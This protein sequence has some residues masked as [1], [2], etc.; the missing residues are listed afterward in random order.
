MKPEAW[1]DA[2]KNFTPHPEADAI[3][4]FAQENGIRVY[5]HTLVVAQP[6]AGLVLPGRRRPAAHRRAR[7][8]SRSSRTGCA[9][10]ILSVA[11]YLSDTYGEFGS[12]T[13]PL[14]AFDVVNEVVSDSGEFA[15]G[16]RRS[17]WYRI[18]G[19]EFIDLAFQYADEAFNDEFAAAGRRPSDHAVHQ[20]LQH[21]AGRQAGSP[22]RAGRAPARARCAGRR[23]GAPVPREPRDAGVRARR[24][25]R[26]VRGPAGRAGGHR[27]RRHHRHAGDRR[28][29]SSSRATTTATRSGSS[30]STP[31]T[32]S[33]S[34][35]GASPTA[36]AGAATP[37]RRSCSTTRCRRSP[38][39]TASSTGSCRRRLRT[40]NVFAERR[41]ARCRR[42]LRRPV[43]AAAA[44]R[45]STTRR[46]FQLRWAPDHL[47]AY[48]TVDDATRAGH[49]RDRDRA[50]R[51]QTVT[52]G[53]DG[54]GDV[55]GV[56]TERDG[57]YDAV[58]AAARSPRRWRRAARC[59]S[60]SG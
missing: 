3:M 18:L 38:P 16:L 8:T 42:D 54:S 12:D 35:C 31:T 52:F 23:R 11:E 59:R 33:R 49:R 43:V 58:V 47:T 2:D 34:R 48:V 46:A 30:G 14:V 41:A 24:G 25:P 7:P 51:G 50:T 22:T 6:D 55:D 9:T 60:T 10:H 17:E 36:A 15:D 5:G 56:V 26:R 20:R 21:R 29:S 37:A 19:E 4:Q 32:C 40:A 39:T 13:N 53:R 1:Y 45:R 44:A 28:R 57:G 27:A